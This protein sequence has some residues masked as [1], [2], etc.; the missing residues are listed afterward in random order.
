MPKKKKEETT[1]PE[2]KTELVPED[3]EAWKKAADTPGQYTVEGTPKPPVTIY[4][5][6][7]GVPYE[8]RSEKF[9]LNTTEEG[10]NN[11]QDNEDVPAIRQWAAKKLKVLK[12][13]EI[14]PGDFDKHLELIVDT[15]IGKIEAPKVHVGEDEE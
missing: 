9:K 10:F 4:I 12:D 13:A 1:E 14:M 8:L 7:Q 2:T 11:R 3:P 5:K 15:I 6:P